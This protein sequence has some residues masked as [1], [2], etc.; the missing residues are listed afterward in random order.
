[1][2]LIHINKE[3]LLAKKGL[4]D[5]RLFFTAVV[6][7]VVARPIGRIYFKINE[8]L[9]NSIDLDRDKKLLRESR[10]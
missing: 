3:S 5:W 8:N 7:R 6:L 4:N 10:E 9:W 2:L 1:M